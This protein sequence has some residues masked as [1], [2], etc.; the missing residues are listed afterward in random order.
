[1]RRKG[2]IALLAVVAAGCGPLSES[3]GAP[4]SIPASA[5]PSTPGSGAAS[6]ASASPAWEEVELPAAQEL[7]DRAI[8]TIELDGPVCGLAANESALWV[9]LVGSGS[10][11][12]IDAATNTVR[13]E[14]TSFDT[15][16]CTIA[17]A[18]GAL[19]VATFQDLIQQIQRVDPATGEVT[20]TIDFTLSS[21][22][23]AMEAGPGGLWVLN[24]QREEVYL[25]DTDAAEIAE[26]YAVGYGASDMDVT[27]EAVWV[28]SD[29]SGGIDRIDIASGEVTNA[30]VESP[31]GV[32]VDDRGVWAYAPVD[33]Q[34]S[35]LS[36]RTFDLVAAWQFDFATGQPDAIGG[37]VWMPSP[38]GALLAF[39]SA[40]GGAAAVFLVPEGLDRAKAALD[41][42][43]LF[44]QVPGLLRIEPSDLEPPA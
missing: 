10:V 2:L 1:M 23:F 17:W 26:T 38:D 33:R 32:A 18:G 4:A 6:P 3:A 11:I 21:S 20:G 44:G 37:I 16:A 40:K 9:T 27:D 8:A 43:W 39:H 12:E 22:I 7:G 36:P 15:D 24:R 28:T 34:L 35:V 19:W 25:V 29:V 5:N 42:L 13:R 41:D 30:P 14:L 31:S